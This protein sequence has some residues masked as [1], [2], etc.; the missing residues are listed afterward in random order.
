MGITSESAG[1]SSS[2][3]PRDDAVA[4]PI[5]E[6][7]RPEPAAPRGGD[8]ARGGE[9]RADDRGEGDFPRKRRRRRRR[10]GRGAEPAE[11]TPAASEAAPGADW[12]DSAGPESDF[13]DE[14]E[15]PDAVTEVTH[16]QELDDRSNRPPRDRNRDRRR[17][18]APRRGASEKVD[19]RFDDDSDEHQEISVGGGAA[20][21]IDSE[22]DDEAGEP[23]TNY[24]NVPTWEEAI[25]YLLH[26]SQVQ[27]E[28]GDGN[29]TSPP[30]SPAQ[31]DQP[32]QT[33]HVGNRKH[34]R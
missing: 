32:R 31:T 11:T 20:E 16:G 10:R 30:R 2:D 14:P 21:P 27:V 7:S 34:R 1:L 28:P 26:P 18:G 15:Q 9:R 6:S 25:S 29:G 3:E 17:E 23:A 4:P 19:D 13:V 33:R 5:R 8:R 22:A 24:E 12:D